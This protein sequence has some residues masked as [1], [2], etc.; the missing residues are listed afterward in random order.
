MYDRTRDWPIYQD[1]YI[2]VGIICFSELS[3]IMVF[4]MKKGC[5]NLSLNLILV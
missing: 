4:I 1:S 3:E 5:L 2:N